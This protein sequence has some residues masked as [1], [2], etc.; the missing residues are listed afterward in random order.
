MMAIQFGRVAKVGKISPFL[1]NGHKLCA[2][3]FYF[4]FRPGVLIFVSNFFDFHLMW[5][6]RFP[7]KEKRLDFFSMAASLLVRHRV[8]VG[9]LAFLGMAFFALGAYIRVSTTENET[10]DVVGNAKKE[11]LSFTRGKAYGYDGS[12]DEMV[13]RE[14]TPRLKV[15]PL[16]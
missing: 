3:Y 6:K 16:S 14:L 12:I 4:L 11:F 10:R 7:N 13:E 9:V 2:V 1:T 8:L 15:W 5:F